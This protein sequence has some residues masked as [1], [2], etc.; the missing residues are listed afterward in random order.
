MSLDNVA[1]SNKH[2]APET[3]M[4]LSFQREGENLNLMLNILSLFLP[5]KSKVTLKVII[6]LI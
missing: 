1:I 5:V 6:E 2:V 3:S 4:S